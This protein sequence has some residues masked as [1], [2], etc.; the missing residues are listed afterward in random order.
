[1]YKTSEYYKTSVYV[2]DIIRLL[3]SGLRIHARD[4]NDA[5]YARMGDLR[6]RNGKFLWFI[7]SSI[8]P[9]FVN[10]V[11]AIITYDS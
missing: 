3:N 11:R 5:V 9:K 1:M 2:G 7:V 10:G 4:D 6:C 8:K